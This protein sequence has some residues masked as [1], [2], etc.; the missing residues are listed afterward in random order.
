MKFAL[1]EHPMTHKFALVA[2]PHRFVDGDPL[3]TTAVDRWFGSREEAIAELPGLLN[4]EEQ[5]VP[6]A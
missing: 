3:P 5:E 1:Y 2:L 4:R 6:T